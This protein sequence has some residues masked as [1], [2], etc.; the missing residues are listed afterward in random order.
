MLLLYCRLHYSWLVA[1]L[2]QGSDSYRAARLFHLPV[3]ENLISK[4]PLVQPY[5]FTYSQWPSCLLLC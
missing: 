5:C 2:V 1:Y 3:L 4:P